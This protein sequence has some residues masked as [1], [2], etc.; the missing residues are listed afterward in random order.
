M[1]LR[2]CIGP[3]C[4]AWRGAVLDV[5]VV[6][7]AERASHRREGWTAAPTPAEPDLMIQ[8]AA[9]LGYCGLGGEA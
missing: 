9:E 8:R 5:R 4:Q 7:G 6:A 2:F 1:V 3:D